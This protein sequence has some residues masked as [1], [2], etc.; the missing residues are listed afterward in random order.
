M[1]TNKKYSVAKVVEENII[2]SLLQKG[3]DNTKMTF[4]ISNKLT[5]I[6]FTNKLTGKTTNILYNNDKTFN[7]IASSDP[8]AMSI[9]ERQRIV[10]RFY[11]DGKG[12]S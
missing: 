9:L 1:T 11:K 7:V 2:I 8:H 3:D 6:T 10:D 4:E 12:L 5:S